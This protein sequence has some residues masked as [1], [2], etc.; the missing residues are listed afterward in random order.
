[1]V[2]GVGFNQGNFA[3]N[4]SEI[5]EISY[6]PESSP[7]TS[8]LAGSMQRVCDPLRHSS[9]DAALHPSRG[10]KVWMKLRRT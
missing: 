8:F 2:E 3:A 10:A 6:K 4:V 1:V 7:Q 9:K 5:S